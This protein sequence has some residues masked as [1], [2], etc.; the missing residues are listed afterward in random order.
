MVIFPPMSRCGACDVLVHERSSY[1]ASLRAIRAY[2]AF[3]TATR[4]LFKAAHKE[5]PDA[6]ECSGLHYLM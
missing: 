2:Q 5:P 6:S 1:L 4:S 3:L